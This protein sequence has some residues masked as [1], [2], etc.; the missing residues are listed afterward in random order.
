[1]LISVLVSPVSPCHI[2]LLKCTNQGDD[3]FSGQD[4]GSAIN[5]KTNCLR[6]I[7]VTLAVRSIVLNNNQYN[8]RACNKVGFLPFI[9]TSQVMIQTTSLP[10]NTMLELLRALT[11]CVCVCVCVKGVTISILNQPKLSRNLELRI[12]NGIV[13]VAKPPCQVR[14]ACQAEKKNHTC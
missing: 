7:F 11:M 14:S 3:I 4:E 1:M 6:F 8:T 10:M 12:K 9:T 13:D 5:Q 2:Y